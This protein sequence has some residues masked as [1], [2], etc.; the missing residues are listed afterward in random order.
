MH[1]MLRRCQDTGLKLNPDKCFVKQEKLRFYGIF[2]SQGGIQ[3][4]PNK[5]TALKQISAPTSRQVLQT[6]LVMENC[7]GLFIPNLSTLKAPLRELLK[8]RAPVCPE[9]RAPRRLQQIHEPISSEV[10]LKYKSKEGDQ[11][12]SGRLAEITG[13]SS[14]TR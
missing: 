9:P 12:T 1:C 2:C 14:L 5:M 10:T 13:R 11:L 3:P 6:F 4:D 8:R 7:M